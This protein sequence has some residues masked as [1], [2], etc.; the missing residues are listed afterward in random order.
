[1]RRH[2]EPNRRHGFDDLLQWK[3][4]GLFE[5]GQTVFTKHL[6]IGQPLMKLESRKIVE[7]R[8]GCAHRITVEIACF[9]GDGISWR[10]ART[11]PRRSRCLRAWKASESGLACTSAAPI[12]T[13][14]TTS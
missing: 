1:M 12:P 5:G 4:R 11:M 3:R 10:I 8:M 9:V 14:S 6:Y 13:P 7:N 2:F